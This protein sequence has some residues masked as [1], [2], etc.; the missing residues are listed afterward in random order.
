MKNPSNRWNK[1]ED[2][3]LVKLYPT[4]TNRELASMLAFKRHT[5]RAIEQRA[6]MLNLRKDSSFIS[7]TVSRTNRE[8]KEEEVDLQKTVLSELLEEVS[9][10]GFISTRRDV[11]INRHYKFPRQ[12]KPFKL[13]VVSD[14][15]LGSVHQQITLLHETYKIFKAEGIKQVLHAGDMIEGNGRLYKGQQFEMFVHGADSL[16][17]YTIKQYPQVPGITT[18]CIAGSHDF[19]YF[20]EDG[21]DALR[22]IADKRPDIK[23]LGVSGAYLNFGKINV[24]LMHGSGGNAY[25]RSYK[26]QKIIEQLPAGEKPH[27]LLLGHYHTTNIL[28]NYRNVAGFQLPCFQT[29]TQ[30]LKAKGLSPEI[31]F[32]I[33]EVF[34]DS[35]GLSHIKPDWRFFY[36]PIG[37]DY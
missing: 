12:L 6:R 33:L 25:A 17:S 4:N 30:Y 28:P 21:Y 29:Q 35:K 23:Y 18:Y 7:Q 15:H 3:S 34:P 20:K 1:K 5:L 8:R 16:V 32:L 11:L 36:T 31:G 14:T 27:I 24:Y 9:R 10:R 13:G 2:K 26:M 19:S 37:G 22:A